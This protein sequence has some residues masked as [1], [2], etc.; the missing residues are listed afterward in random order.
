L[1]ASD[2]AEGVGDARLLTISAEPYNAETL[3]VN[4]RDV[5]TPRASFYKRNHFAIPHIA[6]DDWRL[7]I[8]GNVARPAELT[9]DAVRALPSRTLLVTLECAGNGRAYMEREAEGEPWQY[10]A[11]STAE[12]TGTPLHEA[13]AAVGVGD[14]TREMLF[15]GADAGHVAAAG[16]SLSFVRSLPLEQALHPDTLLAYAMNGEALSAEH[17]FPLRLIVPGWYGMAAVKWLTRIESITEPFRGFYQADRYIMAHPERGETTTTPL[18]TMLAR[19][20]VTYPAEDARLPAGEHIVRGLAWS[21]AATVSRVEIAI[22]DGTDEE[23]A[24]QPAE[25]TSGAEHYAWRQWE[26]RWQAQARGPFTLRCRAFDALGNTQ[27]VTA[28]WNRLGY[29]NN[30]IQHVRVE[31]V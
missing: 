2:A 11:V 17:G 9:L 10:G 19:S 14:G 7:Q 15:T 27:P 1:A 30:A 31:V 3:L 22:G 20:L 25:F 4:H 5:V 28:D 13:L 23:G 12:W 21:G 16:T 18:T 29:A 6:A 8:T 24:W 26:Y